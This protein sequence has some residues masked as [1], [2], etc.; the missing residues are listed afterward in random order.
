MA[1]LSLL[2]LIP[3]SQN[4]SF[5]CYPWPSDSSV[6][7]HWFPSIS[8]HL[9][10]NHF[11]FLGDSLVKNSPANAGGTCLIL[12][13]GRFPR[14]GN[15]NALQYSFLG[16]LMDRGAWWATMHGAAESDTTDLLNNNKLWITFYLLNFF[17]HFF[18]LPWPH[19]LSQLRILFWPPCWLCVTFMYFSKFTSP[20][21]V[22]NYQL[23]SFS[24]VPCRLFHSSSWF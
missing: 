22:N 20:L 10:V 16:N 21:L 23:R 9:T 4:F 6:Q 1:L 2:S 17:S 19:T 18:A 5:F 8:L 11:V 3:L 12:G 13:I 14:E 15:G 7:W 24:S